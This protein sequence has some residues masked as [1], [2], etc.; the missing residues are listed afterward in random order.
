MNKYLILIFITLIDLIIFRILN[1]I[2]I[3]LYKKKNPKS[4]DLFKFKERTN[5]IINIIIVISLFIIWENYLKNLVTI[6]S[7]ISAGATIALREVILNLIAGVYIKWAKTFVVEDRIEV[8]D[9]KYTLKGDVV[10]ISVMSFKVLEVSDKD[11]GHQ[12]NGII[13]NIP[14]SVVFSGAIRNYTTG[15]K[16][17]WSEFHVPIDINANLNQNKK[18]LYK[19][20]K[21]NEI[22]ND[23]PKKMNKA[24][25]IASM[26]YRIYY[27]NLEPIIYTS[28]ENDHVLLT[29]RYLVHP[30]KERTVEDELWLKIL[31]QYKKKKIDLH[32][33]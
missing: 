13:I 30:K 16:Y 25:G 7:F 29:I 4:K 21:K 19:I 24:I 33:K 23:I 28:L 6:I 18:E 20:V 1:K 2:L 17:I 32:I 31:E 12:S 26:T 15:F 5:L 3:R 14:N 11:N 10:L 22:I 27:N 8:K 9:S